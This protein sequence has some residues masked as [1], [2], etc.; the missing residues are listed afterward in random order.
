[1]V[2]GFLFSFRPCVRCATSEHVLFN[3]CCVSGL[4]LW[5]FFFKCLFRS[6][7]WWGLRGCSAEIGLP[8]ISSH[9]VFSSP[10]P[11]EVTYSLKKFSG[12]LSPAVCPMYWSMHQHLHCHKL[13]KYNIAL[14]LDFEKWKG[15]DFALHVSASGQWEVLWEASG[16]ACRSHDA[17]GLESRT[18][19]GCRWS[20]MGWPEQK[21]V[22]RE[23]TSCM[24]WAE[25]C[26]CSQWRWLTCRGCSLHSITS[27]TGSGPAHG[28]TGWTVRCVQQKF[29]IPVQFSK[30]RMRAVLRVLSCNSKP[31]KL[32]NGRRM[33]LYD[34][35]I[36][37]QFFWRWILTATLV[38]VRD[39]YVRNW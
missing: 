21:S 28:P 20:S 3:G 25:P 14:G 1:M 33:M 17:A 24:T 26:L 23:I 18:D 9:S 29:G 35:I 6:L 27:C 19:Q 7:K 36:W 2:F 15:E 22:R 39:I 10:Q 12:L 31:P 4:E 34:D 11:Y 13:I 37:K 8:V 30:Q 38:S 32:V 5:F 16:G